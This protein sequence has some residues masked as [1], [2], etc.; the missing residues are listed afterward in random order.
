[1]IYVKKA[2]LF[3]IK[4]LIF[5]VKIACISLISN[6]YF[7]ITKSNLFPINIRMSSIFGITMFVFYIFAMMGLLYL[8]ELEAKIVKYIEK[9]L[10]LK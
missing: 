7:K 3:F 4:L 5:L 6:V 10:N 1:M 2:I 8:F 9:K